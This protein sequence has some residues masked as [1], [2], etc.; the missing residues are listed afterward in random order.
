MQFV[1]VAPGTFQMGAKGSDSDSNENS[2]HGVTL[3][4]GYW[5][6]KY[7]V[8][9]DEYEPITGWNPS[10]VKGGRK[11]LEQV[12]WHDAVRFCQK[13]TERE[14]AAGRLPD[15]Y[16]YRLPTEA[17]WEFAARGGNDSK[18]YKYSGSDN[19]DNVG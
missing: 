3:N 6:G 12:G 7:E 2:G 8:T 9:Q 19:I 15:G 18:G 5:I 13:L 4:N 14:C 11:P 17:Q 10:Y 16:E 1:Y